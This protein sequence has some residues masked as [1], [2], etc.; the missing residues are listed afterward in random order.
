MV[1]IT[2]IMVI[3]EIIMVILVIITVTMVMVNMVI[4]HGHGRLA[5]KVKGGAKKLNVFWAFYLANFRR[6]FLGNSLS[7]LHKNFTD[8]EH[9]C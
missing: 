7:D 3:M 6:Q 2:V 9:R 8:F 1:I 5:F 4:H